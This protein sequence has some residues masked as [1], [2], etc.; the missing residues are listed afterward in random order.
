MGKV[1]LQMSKVWNTHL[2]FL[3]SNNGLMPKDE[4]LTPRLV[5]WSYTFSIFNYVTV[6]NTI[7]E[8]IIFYGNKVWRKKNWEVWKDRVST[9]WSNKIQRNNY[10]Q[11]RW[12]FWHFLSSKGFNRHFTFWQR[13]IHFIFHQKKTLH[14]GNS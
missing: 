3:K 10:Q 8:C 14:I 4:N 5:N 2:V 7:K 1:L 9:D 13:T 6:I 12:L 11:S